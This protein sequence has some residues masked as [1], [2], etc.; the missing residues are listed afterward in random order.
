MRVGIPID[1]RRY[2]SLR[3]ASVTQEEEAGH[4][5]LTKRALAVGSFLS[6][7]LAVGSNYADAV[8]K[9]SY[10]T[11]DFTT[12]GAIFLF[13]VLVGGLNTLYK[14]TGR[15]VAISGALTVLV[16]LAW[17]VHYYPFDKGLV[18]YSP[19]ALFSSFLVLS[20][21]ANTVLVAAGRRS[22][23]LNRSELIVVY[24]MLIVVASVS[25]MGLCETI[26]PAISGAFYYASPENKWEELLFPH[27]PMEIMANDGMENAKFFEGYG[28]GVNYSIPWM[29]W[30]RPMLLWAVMLLSLYVTMVSIMVILRRQWMDRERLSYPLVQAAQVI[31]RG[32]DEQSMVNPFFKSKAMWAGAALPILVGLFTGLNKYLGGWPL[33]PTAW[34]FPIGFG[35]SINMTIS[36]A[37]VGFSYLLGPDIA[38]GIWG[39]ALVSKFERMMFVA[40]GVTKQ[41]D[42]WSVRVTELINYQGLG[43][44]IVFVAIGL[45][46]G[47]E[48]LKQVA[49]NFLGKDTELSDDDEIMSYRAAVLGTLVGT[50]V[51]I[52]WFTWL[53]TPLWASVLFIAVLM[54]IFTGLSRVVAESGV[55]AIITPMNACDFMVFGLGSKL[56]GATAITNISLGYIFAADIRVFLMGLVANGLKLIEGMN[57]HSRR[58]VFWSI[59]IAIFLGVTGSLYTVLELAYRD[60]GINF[61]GWFYKSMPAV[62]CRTAIKGME[63]PG[64]YWPGMGFMGVGAVGMLA[65][66]WLHQRFLWWPLHPIGFPIMTSWVVDWMW[67]SVFFA[68]LVKVFVLKYGGAITFAKSR[69]FFLGM[70]AGRMFISGGWLVVDYLTGTVSNSIFWI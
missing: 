9:G 51:M 5:P 35:Q 48:H 28:A 58:I 67:F 13:L 42:V 29:L 8:L 6:F 69:N 16:A 37:V 52:G 30:L 33:I 64:V 27:L 56:L 43:A 68:W 54:I 1:F 40:N 70:I 18:A 55:A 53:G 21:F 20:L 60:G 50:A 4:Q 36:F 39:F 62:I 49:L 44:L 17:A 22:L 15:T 7:F 38:M 25:T 61:S 34:S 23:A 24:I 66:T 65:L 3:G 26:L 63:T 46:V 2:L 19:G 12:P 59:L 14:I 57:T 11:L 47:R 10:M 45:W 41:Q 31:I 32:E